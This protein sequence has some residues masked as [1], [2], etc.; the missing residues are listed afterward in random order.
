MGVP[1]WWQGLTVI[2]VG[3]AVGLLGVLAWHRRRRRVPG[4]LLAAFGVLAA[5]SALRL[6]APPTGLWRW[7]HGPLVPVGERALFTLFLLL[8]A[9][10]LLQPLFP[11]YRQSLRWLLGSHIGFWAL[12]SGAVWADFGAAWQPR[13]HF[14]NHWGSVAFALYEL[15]LMA[16]LLLTVGYVYRHT[17]SRPVLWA[18]TAFGVWFLS[19]GIHLVASLRGTD[20]PME[21][22][23]WIRMG[24]L[25]AFL[26]LALAF[27]RPDP[28]RRAFAERY[29][30]DAQALVRRLEAELAEMAAAQARLE[31]RQRIARELHDSVSQALFSVELQLSTADMLLDADPERARSTLAQAR[32]T[33]HEAAN[34]LRALIA[35]LRPPALAGKSLPEAL[36][37]LARSLEESEGVPV[38]VRLDVEGRLS[39]AEEGELYRIVY[40]ALTN[41]VKHAQPQHIVVALDLHPPAFRLT[42]AD[43]G[44]GFDPQAIPPGHWGLTGM[45]ER[46]ERLGATFRLTT[47][48]GQGTRIE[49]VRREA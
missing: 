31:E 10:A 3:V 36:T 40:E 4:A 18:G 29:F 34:D 14:V 6:L 7:A 27:L 30:A 23:V 15:I 20:I 47:A 24:N 12:L 13:A 17:R 25:A 48:P 1:W 26:L 45:Q 42:V 5:W 22:G 32:R 37:D 43:D 38:E 41:A 46:A 19:T 16:V 28:S 33:V 9:Y 49:V 8:T 35:D 11:A 21:P 39:E 2:E 44:H